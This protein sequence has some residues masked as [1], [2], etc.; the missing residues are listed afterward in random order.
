[1]D[2]EETLKQKT[3]HARKKFACGWWSVQHSLMN[4]QNWPNDSFILALIF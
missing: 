3:S 2:W 1:M 4:G